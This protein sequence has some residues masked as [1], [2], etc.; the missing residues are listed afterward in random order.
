MYFASALIVTDVVED[1]QCTLK[2]CDTPLVVLEVSGDAAKTKEDSRSPRGVMV[3][4]LGYRQSGTQM[5]KRV[6]MPKDGLRRIGSRNRKINC[7]ARIACGT[8]V[9]CQSG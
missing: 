2:V 1:F 4:T 9:M 8:E 3:L 7:V 5:R 6:F